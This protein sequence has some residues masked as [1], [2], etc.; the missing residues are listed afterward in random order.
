MTEAFIY[1][2]LC[3]TQGMT[4]CMYQALTEDID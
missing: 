2:K 1:M 3:M 4:S